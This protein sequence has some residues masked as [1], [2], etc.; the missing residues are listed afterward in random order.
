MRAPELDL[1]LD[2]FEGPFDLLLT[3]V[4]REELAPRR[5]RRRRHRPRVRRAAGGT[6]AARPRGLRRVPRPRRV[7]AR[8]EGPRSV[9]RRG[10]SIS[11]SSTRRRRPRSSPGASRSTGASRSR[12]PGSPSGSSTSRTATSASARRRSRS[13]PSGGSRPATRSSSPTRCACSRR[14]RR[15]VSL[16]HMGLRFPPIERFLDRFRDAAA[17]PPGVHARRGGRG[18]L[19]ARA[20]G[21]V[22][23]RPRAVQG[24]RGAARAGGAVRTDQGF[25]PDVE[26]STA[27]RTARSA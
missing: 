27:W 18:A 19:P 2:T 26:R 5:G 4:L 13:G 8:A 23:R 17:P 11:P 7:A 10:A 9:P 12:R 24:G 16:A 14:S 3:L 25:A 20:G 1:D 21:R 22:S 6:G 15:S